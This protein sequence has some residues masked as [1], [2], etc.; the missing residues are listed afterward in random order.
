MFHGSAD[1]EKA[2]GFNKIFAT[3][4]HSSSYTVPGQLKESYFKLP[5]LDL[6]FSDVFLLLEL[7]EDSS[8]A[9]AGELAF[10]FLL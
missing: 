3:V 2:L 7:C 6:S 1:S 4:L 8:A 9:G 5:N 10:F